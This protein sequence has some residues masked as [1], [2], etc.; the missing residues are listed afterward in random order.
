MNK[1]HTHT[2]RVEAKWFSLTPSV[3]TYFSTNLEKDGEKKNLMEF[4]VNKNS[5]LPQRET[6]LTQNSATVV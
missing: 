4:I 2:H 5:G 1:M 6:A 3:F